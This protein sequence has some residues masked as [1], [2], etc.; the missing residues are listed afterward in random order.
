MDHHLQH[1]HRGRYHPEGWLFHTSRAREAIL[2]NTLLRKRPGE[3][4]Q[5]QPLLF[6]VEFSTGSAGEPTFGMASRG[7]IYFLLYVYFKHFFPVD[8]GELPELK[9]YYGEKIRFDTGY[10]RIYTKG[11][12]N[13]DAGFEI[14]LPD[15]IELLKQI[16]AKFVF[17]PDVD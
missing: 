17:L 10:I 11:A 1:L 14:F 9:Q 6:M 5:Q 12:T 4:I 2:E 15:N 13:S 7:I 3:R 8:T 16:K